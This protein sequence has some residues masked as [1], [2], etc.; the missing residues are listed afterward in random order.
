MTAPTKLFDHVTQRKL[1]YDCAS[2]ER[3]KK[4]T[5]SPSQFQSAFQGLAF[6]RQAFRSLA[7][8]GRWL[9]RLLLPVLVDAQ[10]RQKIILPGD[11]A[12]ANV[13][14]EDN[15][16]RVY[17]GVLLERRLA[18]KRLGADGALE[19]LVAGVQTQMVLEILAARDALAA[20]PAQVA[21]VRAVHERAVRVQPVLAHERFV[22]VGARMLLLAVVDARMRLQ[23]RAAR[24]ALVAY[25]AHVRRVVDAVHQPL[26]PVEGALAAEAAVARLAHVARLRAVLGA[27]VVPQPVLGQEDL[28]ARVADQLVVVQMVD[29]LSAQQVR[30]FAHCASIRPA[31]ALGTR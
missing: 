5:K 14:P 24:V 26:V 8:Q 16:G 21:A 31:A 20:V 18:G 30:R 15:G 6:R 23:A 4:Q 19:R 17:H 13:A 3:H 1:V 29:Q 25:V 12:L 2:A 7:F 22:A 28:T 27:D 11:S 9:A 10:V